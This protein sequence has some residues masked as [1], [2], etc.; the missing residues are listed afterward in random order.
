MLEGSSAFWWNPLFSCN[1]R[2]FYAD[3][4]ILATTKP[5]IFQATRY[6]LL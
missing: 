4:G 5:L 2:L 6:D 1:E 3:S